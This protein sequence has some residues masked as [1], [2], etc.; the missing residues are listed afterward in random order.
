MSQHGQFVMFP[1]QRGVGGS[2]P[3]LFDREIAGRLP[4]QPGTMGVD[5]FAHGPAGEPGYLQGPLITIPV[6]GND[7][8]PALGIDDGQGVPDIDIG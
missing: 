7:P 5:E 2:S 4:L 3:L 1:W 8:A 6:A